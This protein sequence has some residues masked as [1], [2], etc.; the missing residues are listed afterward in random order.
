MAQKRVLA[1]KLIF[2]YIVDRLPRRLCVRV[3][4][5]VMRSKLCPKLTN[6]I[7]CCCGLFCVAKI[8]SRL[9]HPPSL[10]QYIP[11]PLPLSSTLRHCTVVFCCLTRRGALSSLTFC[12]SRLECQSL[13]CSVGLRC[14]PGLLFWPKAVKLHETKQRQECKRVCVSKR[15]LQMCI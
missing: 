14:W 3:C 8:C 6:K 10:Q 13:L 15:C 11:P 5:C 7:C 12:R 9:L 4:V 2:I 1:L